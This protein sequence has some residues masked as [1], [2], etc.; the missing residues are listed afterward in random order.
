MGGCALGINKTNVCSWNNII[1]GE[2][3]APNFEYG[4]DNIL[5][6]DDAGM[7]TKFGRDNIGLG[8]AA[9]A[10]LISG[11]NNIALGQCAGRVAVG[12]GVPGISTTGIGTGNIFLGCRATAPH[13]SPSN[14]L[15]IGNGVNNMNGNTFEETTNWIIGDPNYNTVSYTHLRA[16]ET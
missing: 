2:N 4:A 3:S 11:N 13:S 8:V 15:V 14:Y 1:M 9:L 7:L 6:G 12:P 10:N 16:H 5:M